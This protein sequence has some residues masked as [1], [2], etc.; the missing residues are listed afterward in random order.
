MS[1][2]DSCNNIIVRT[3]KLICLWFTSRYLGT[4]CWPKP[5]QRSTLGRETNDDRVTIILL[6]WLHSHDDAIVLPDPRIPVFYG[7]STCMQTTLGMLTLPPGGRFVGFLGHQ[8]GNTA[9]PQPIAQG[10]K[11]PTQRYLDIDIEVPYTLEQIAT[12]SATPN[13][14]CKHSIP[15]SFATIA[16]NVPGWATVIVWHN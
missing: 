5:Y 4:N 16:A 11:S 8:P 9:W 15:L 2:R 12:S 1:M 13:L 7:S 6:T 3:V 10:L 14:E